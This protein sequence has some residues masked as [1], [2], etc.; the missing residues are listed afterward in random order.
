MIAFI[1]EN[2][3]TILISSVILVLVTWISISLIKKK[4]S[5]KSVGCGCGCDSCPSASAC[6]KN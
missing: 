1:A 3:A 6:H 2:L 4:K 5:G